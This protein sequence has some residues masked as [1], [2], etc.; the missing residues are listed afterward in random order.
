MNIKQKNI[1]FLV[2]LTIFCSIS[3]NKLNNL[4][5]QFTGNSQGGSTSQGPSGNS[6]GGSTS[7]GPSGSSQG[8]STSQGPS[9]NS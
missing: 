2:L 1:F 6:Q 8:G 9:G 4:K 3:L 5:K 7:Q